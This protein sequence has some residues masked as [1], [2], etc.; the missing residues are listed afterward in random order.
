MYS[1]K[2]GSFDGD[3]WETVM[4]VCFRLKYEQEHY[5]CIVASPGDFGIEGF[6][7]TGKVFQCYCPDNLTT[8]AE[9][10]E[11]QRD[12]ITR[13][14]RKLQTYEAQLK[15]YLGATKIKEWIFVTPEYKT[16]D[17]IKHCI[18]KAEETKMLGLQIID[19]D[20]KVLIHDIDN[21]ATEIFVALNADNKKIALLPDQLDAA[22]DKVIKWKEQSISLVDNAVRKHGKRFPANTVELDQK[23]N[24]LTNT[25]VE[26]FLN[27][28]SILRK[29]R[30]MHPDHYDRFIA[31]VGQIENDVREKCMFPSN[32]NN[33]RYDSINKMVD[34][35]IRGSFPYL[36]ETAILKLTR[37]VLAD[38]LVRCPIDFE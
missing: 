23:V 17:L 4:Q 5:Q 2:H 10:Y 11:K 31:L 33:E 7:S 18:D 12:K 28:E 36:D 21:F 20:F 27:R 34:A 29:W 15:G 22:P 37:G 16:K 35:K 14:L 19:T 9:L 6:T 26:D 30:N 3:S 13:D 32:D 25:T 24:R 8:T 1:T 38:W